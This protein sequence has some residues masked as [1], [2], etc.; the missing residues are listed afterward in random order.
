MLKIIKEFK[1]SLMFIMLSCL[2]LTSVHIYNKRIKVVVDGVADTY[3]TNA[4]SYDFVAKQLAHKYSFDDYVIETSSDTNVVRNN[5]ILIVNSK[6]NIELTS[7]SQTSNIETYS[8]TPEELVQELGYENSKDVK[9]ITDTDKLLKD[10]EKIRIIKVEEIYEEEVSV[11]EVERKEVDDP[12]VFKGITTVVS[13]GIASEYN[14]KYLT[15]YYDGVIF[16]K[17]LVDRKII[18]EGTPTTVSIGTKEIPNLPA[19]YASGDT[20]WDSVA[21]CEAGGDWAK[22][23]G[24]GYYGGLQ[25]S[26]ATWKTAS[27]AVG[28]NAEFAHQASREEQIKAAEWMLSRSSWKQQWPSCSKKLGLW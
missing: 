11:E 23:T 22:N 27:K 16:E 25:F 24:N 8:A 20:V 26:A 17:K 5:A 4:L 13:T 21:K 28:V 14:N 6:K 12:N 3:Y 2:V 18:K 1:I 19:N 7:N 10:I 15:T 9:Y